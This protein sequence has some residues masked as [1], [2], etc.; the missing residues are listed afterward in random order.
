MC[1]DCAQ[2]RARAERLQAEIRKRDKVI[3]A[4]RKVIKAQD[5]Q[6]DAVRL[7]AYHAA[8]EAEQKLGALDKGGLGKGEYTFRRRYIEGVAWCAGKVYGLVYIS[9]SKAFWS[10]LAEWRGL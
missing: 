5:S 8:R 4:A 6:L 10:L 9:W 1:D 7:F 3:D 2:Y